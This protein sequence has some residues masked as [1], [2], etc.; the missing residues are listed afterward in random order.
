LLIIGNTAFSNIGV[1]IAHVVAQ[2]TQPFTISHG[3]TS[4]PFSNIGSAAHTTPQTAAHCAALPLNV[5]AI[6]VG[7]VASISHVQNIFLQDWNQVSHLKLL[8]VTSFTHS[9]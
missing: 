3:V 8:S 5:F 6:L 4:A 1:A 9:T 7:Q 2:I